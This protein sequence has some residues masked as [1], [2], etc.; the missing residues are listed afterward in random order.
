MLNIYFPWK[1]TFG[2]TVKYL[3]KHPAIHKILS[4]QYR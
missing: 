1:W 3:K 2:R 4:D